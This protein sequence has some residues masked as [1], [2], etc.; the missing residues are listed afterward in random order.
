MLS[1]RSHRSAGGSSIRPVT[2]EPTALS[3]VRSQ[4]RVASATRVFRSSA[5]HRATSFS[6]FSDRCVVT[7]RHVES[8][9]WPSSEGSWSTS[10][11]C[12]G[13]NRASSSGTASVT[14]FAHSSFASFTAPAETNAKESFEAFIAF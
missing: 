9:D 1:S 10:R 4:V 7:A 5:T 14:A 11:L 3:I 13:R 12:P 6:N 2:W 8:S